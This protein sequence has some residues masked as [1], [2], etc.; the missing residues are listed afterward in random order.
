[1]GMCA[2]LGVPICVVGLLRVVVV[3]VVASFEWKFGGAGA[4]KAMVVRV[5]MRMN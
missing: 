4:A 1:M 2:N 5:L 3:V